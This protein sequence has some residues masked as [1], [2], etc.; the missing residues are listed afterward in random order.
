MGPR[1]GRGPRSER[2]GAARHDNRADRVHRRGDACPH[3]RHDDRL[4]RRRPRQRHHRQ[5]SSA[6]RSCSTSATSPKVSSPRVSCRSA[7]M[8]IPSEIVVCRRRGRGTRSPEG[9]QGRSPH[10]LQEARRVRARL[11]QDRREVRVR[12]ERRGRG[13]RGRQ[14]RSH[15]RHRP[16]RLPARLARRS[17]PRQGPRDLSS[18]TASRPESSRWTATA[19]TSSSRAAWCSKRAASTS[20]PRS[21]ASCRRA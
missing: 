3:R 4:R 8:S 15:P 13:H 2:A 16:A 20:A 7:R 1:C 17:S 5:A 11:V 18:A 9:G 6:T 21:S 10:P 19:T 14:G 12:R